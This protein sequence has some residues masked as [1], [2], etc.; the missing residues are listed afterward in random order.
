MIRV[1]LISLVAGCGFT[2]TQGTSDARTSGPDGN[3]GP[4]AH[5]VDA[6]A[7]LDAH[8]VMDGPGPDPFDP[9]MCP[10]DYT[11]NTI[12]ASPNTRYK[13]LTDMAPVITQSN[14]CNGD[15][16][17]W[18]HLAVLDTVQEA[19]QIN[20]HMGGYFYYVGA[21]QPAGQAMPGDGWLQLTGAPVP[22]EMWQPSQ[23][24]D[25]GNAEND[26]QNFASV[27]DSS[28]LMNDVAR[29]YQYRAVCEC[30]GEAISPAALAA[31]NQ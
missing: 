9:A 16:P 21:V 29:G 25:N 1:A 12:T 18:T 2:P 20:A 27:D 14:E 17:G 26:E 10:V 28:G 8:V 4:D 7:V 19:Q 6:H 5:V 11:N 23:P 3:V 30:D 15:H 24:N 22:A 31:L 13:I